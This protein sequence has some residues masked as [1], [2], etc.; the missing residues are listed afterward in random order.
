MSN[1]IQ[2]AH[3]PWSENGLVRLSAILTPTGPLPISRSSWWAGVASGRY[4]K[5]VK[6]GPRITAWRVED[7]RKLIEQGAA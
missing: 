5:P 7:I 2:N 1:N 3:I 4:P 6:L